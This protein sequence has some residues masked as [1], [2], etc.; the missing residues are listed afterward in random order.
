LP[1]LK[2]GKM[3][4]DIFIDTAIKLGID[5]QLRNIRATLHPNYRHDRNESQH[6]RSLLASVLS[7][8]SNCIDIGAYRGRFLAEITRIA[9][10]GRHIAYEP[11]PYLHKFLINQ[12]PSVDIRFVAVSNE[13][14]EKSFTYVKNIPARSGF[15]ERSF[16]ERQQ[17]EKLIVQTVTLDDDLPPEYVPALIKIDVEGA[18]RQVL[19][20]AIETISKHKPIVIFEHGKGGATHYGTSPRDIYELLHDRAGL[21]IFDLDGNGPYNLSQFEESYTLDN[22]WDYVARR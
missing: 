18:E 17:I 2:E 1:R 19:E 15:N 4:R 20:G 5:D 9:P 8:D 6:L 14:G 7:Q 16:A 10:R 12:F 13:Q 21:R 3:L 22:R 11:L